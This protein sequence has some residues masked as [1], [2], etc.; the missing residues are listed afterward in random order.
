MY[1][2]FPNNY[3]WTIRLNGIINESY[4]GG[5]SYAEITQVIAKLN[6]NE[7]ESWIREWEAMGDR[8]RGLAQ[9]AEANNLFAI[10]KDRYFRATNYY[11]LE[12]VSMNHNDPK[13]LEV[14]KKSLECFHRAIKVIPNIEPVKVPY[15]K[16]FLPGYF[17]NASCQGERRPVMVLVD[18]VYG[19]AEKMF[20]IMGRACPEYGISA[21]CLDGP[22]TGGSILLNGLRSRYDSE[23]QGKAIFDFLQTRTDVDTQR[24]ALV[25]PS[26][27][28]YYA[29]R[30]V[31]F[32]KRFAAC[33]CFGAIFDYGEIWA[34]RP[35]DHAFAPFLM[36]I[37]GENNMAAVREK[38]KQY[39]LKKVAPLIECP[40]LILHGENDQ[41]VSI[42]HAYR[43]YEALR[44]MKKLK[45]F[46][47]EEGGD[48]H[49]QQDNLGGMREEV[50]SWLTSIFSLKSS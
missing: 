39:N 4:L 22:G 25:S 35:D 12:T 5:G 14:Y 27:G 15:E 24:V 16:S 48:Q 49:C 43:T 37:M 47:K 50:F 2:F 13:L 9:N 28:G 10:S 21:L 23:A 34:D 46:T 11:Q 3:W 31:A 19:T 42:S 18:G 20:F 32:E 41:Q 30:S 8:V 40:T 44:C 38:L 17:I 36:W 7:P 6:N 1:N 29:A 26:L 45:I 33:V